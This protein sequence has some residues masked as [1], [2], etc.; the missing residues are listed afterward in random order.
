MNLRHSNFRYNVQ[1]DVTNKNFHPLSVRYIE[2]LLYSKHSGYKYI[3]AEL[4]EFFQEFS[5][6]EAYEKFYT[7]VDIYSLG[8]IMKEIF[9]V[10][11]NK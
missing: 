7:K 2:L 8:V 5:D 11:S 1:L 10:D 6:S 4:Q 3:A 9:A